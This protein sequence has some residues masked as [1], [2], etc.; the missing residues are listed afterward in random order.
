MTPLWV[1]I[2]GIEGV[3]KTYLGG[4]LAARLGIRCRLL[5]EVTDHQ[6]RILP[7]RVAAALSRAGD[8][9]LRTGH[10]ATETLALLALKAGEHERIRAEGGTSAGIVLEDRGVD[11]VAIYQSLILA[12]LDAPATQ[13]HRLMELIYA[14]AGH[15]R[16]VPDRTLLLTDDLGTC[17]S[18]LEQRTGQTIAASDRVLICR[19]ARLFAGQA[20]HEPSRFRVVDCAGRAAEE[21]VGELVQICTSGPGM[22]EPTC[23]I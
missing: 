6:P 20:A 9:W 14:T 21:I 11:S 2:E 22:A 23:A 17:I 16:P 5:S 10:P 15:W 3:G 13:V 18:R 1:T 4:L 19:V 7:S 12:G 8:L